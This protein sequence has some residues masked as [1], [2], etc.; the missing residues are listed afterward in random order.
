MDKFVNNF[1]G[2]LPPPLSFD[3]RLQALFRRF[4]KLESTQLGKRKLCNQK[5]KAALTW[6]ISSMHIKLG[7]GALYSFTW[8]NLCK[9][10]RS[11]VTKISKLILF[12]GFQLVGDFKTKKTSE[13][14][15]IIILD[16]KSYPIFF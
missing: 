13:Y 7:P 15:R 9:Q 1:L 3:S 12:R 2:R 4:S 14:N 10:P 5:F 16:Q 6:I 11:S 8:K